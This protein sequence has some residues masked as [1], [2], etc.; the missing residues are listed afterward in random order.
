MPWYLHLLIDDKKA[1]TQNFFNENTGAKKGR[2]IPRI[3]SYH[4]SIFI[5]RSFSNGGK[6]QRKL[7]SPFLPDSASQLCSP[8][9]EPLLWEG[10]R[11]R[12][13]RRSL[14]S[15][16]SRGR[17]IVAWKFINRD[18]KQDPSVVLVPSPGWNIGY[19]A[20]IFLASKRKKKMEANKNWWRRE[21]RDDPDLISSMRRVPLREEFDSFEQEREGERR[22]ISFLVEIIFN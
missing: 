20:A 6:D 11:E 17:I 10:E 12:K 8:L 15:P 14:F 1:R 22:K 4:V 18:N 13:K 7:K 5:R 3:F 19:Y 16:P 2:N 21:F 9:L